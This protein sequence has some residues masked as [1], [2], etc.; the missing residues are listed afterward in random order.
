ME[1]REA[2]YQTW[3]LVLW[4]TKPLCLADR[5]G[6]EFSTKGPMLPVDVFY[7]TGVHFFLILCHSVS[8]T[9]VWWERPKER[10]HS[11]DRGLRWEGSEWILGR[12][13]GG[14][15]D[16]V[17]L[18]QGPVAGS[19]EHGDEPSSSGAT[20]IVR[21][22]W[23]I[24]TLFQKTVFVSHQYLALPI[25]MNYCTALRTRLTD[26]HWEDMCESQHQKLNLIVK[27]N[28]S[29]AVTNISLMADFVKEN[30]VIY[31]WVFLQQ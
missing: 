25:L 19:C 8:K 27:D 24:V 13:A 31:T 3:I 30:S 14:G 2:T 17:S 15:V 6:Q 5:L 20:E 22:V 16:S 29:K 7:A 23:K 10:D 12:S 18:G 4:D 11:E 9:R 26:G 21:Y 28:Q 1:K